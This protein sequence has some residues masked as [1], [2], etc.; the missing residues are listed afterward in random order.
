MS[1][2][3]RPSTVEKT[4]TLKPLSFKW[5][6]K[7]RVK[8]GKLSVS[9]IP[10]PIQTG[11][12]GWPGPKPIRVPSIEEIYLT[13]KSTTDKTTATALRPYINSNKHPKHTNSHV[14]QNKNFDEPL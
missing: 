4:K 8:Q 3:L 1:P 13:T 14:N 6:I 2:K 9:R 5:D 7:K 12:L 11:I 10:G